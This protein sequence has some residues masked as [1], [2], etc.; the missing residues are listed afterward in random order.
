MSTKHTLEHI[1]TKNLTSRYEAQ[2]ILGHGGMGTVIKALDKTLNRE[3]AIKQ[4]SAALQQSS[5]AT[6][7]FLTEAR[8]LAELSHK[9]LVRVFDVVEAPEGVAMIQEFIHG[10]PL[11]RVLKQRSHLPEDET[12]YIA[13]QL[14]CVVGYLHHMNYLHR[15]LKPANIILQSDGLLRLIDFGLSR[16]F[17]KLLERGTEVRGTPAYMAPEQIK[18]RTLSPAT[19]IYQ[20]GVTLYE[21]LVGSLPFET[22]G[23]TYA[24]AYAHVNETPPR[25]HEQRTEI[26]EAFSQ[27]IDKCL[28][29][30]PRYRYQNCQALLNDLAKLH[31]DLFERPID[32]SGLVIPFGDVGEGDIKVSPASASSSGQYILE[33]RNT[34]PPHR[35]SSME[36]EHDT[37]ITDP[38]VSTDAVAR[39]IPDDEIT[40][41]SN[42]RISTQEFEELSERLQRLEKEKLKKNRSI[43]ISAT[44]TAASLIAL[45]AML[46]YQRSNS[47]EESTNTP[48]QTPD[49][50]TSLTTP[51]DAPPEPVTKQITSS[52]VEVTAPPAVDLGTTTNTTNNTDSPKQPRTLDVITSATRKTSARKKSP[53]TTPTKPETHAPDMHTFDA[54]APTQKK[55]GKGSYLDGF[56]TVDPNDQK[57]DDDLKALSEEP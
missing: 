18:S 47:G 52:P 26:S 57:L 33:S 38:E 45:I 10:E 48:V 55:S 25:A 42:A 34:T 24:L 35:I 4:L 5:S 29:K 46:A 2:E 39:E 3:V 54:G 37:P 21:L 1:L 40:D 30:N 53:K 23:D 22:N 7:L 9:N 14:T 19:D 28:K 41:D 32:E 13:I 15:D 44:L 16:K 8:S 43:A 17:D 11:E 50:T 20:I 27:I 51:S 36:A 6:E 31:L 12:L 49:S 56:K